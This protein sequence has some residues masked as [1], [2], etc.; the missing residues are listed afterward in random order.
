MAFAVLG[1]ADDSELLVGLIYEG[2]HRPV[3]LYLFESNQ[4]LK[5][6]PERTRPAPNRLKE[7]AKTTV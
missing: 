7:T 2:P 4:T 3:S 5:T 1:V 6:P